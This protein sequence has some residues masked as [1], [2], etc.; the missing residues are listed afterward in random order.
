MFSSEQYRAKASEYA[1]LSGMANGAN[2]VREFERLERSF[3][4]LA[5]NAQWVSENHAQTVHA[6]QYAV[7]PPTPDAPAQSI[8]QQ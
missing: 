1:K 5:D 2:E 7:A 4:D 8:S 6:T 3:T